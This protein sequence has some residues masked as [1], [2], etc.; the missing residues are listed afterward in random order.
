MTV[1]QQVERLDIASISSSKCVLTKLQGLG[2]LLQFQWS[3][4][5]GCPSPCTTHVSLGLLGPIVLDG[6]SYPSIWVFTKQGTCVHGQYDHCVTGKFH[7]YYARSCW[8]NGPGT[9]HVK[10][11]YGFST[12]GYP[13]KSDTAWQSLWLPPYETDEAESWNYNVLWG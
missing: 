4:Y 8:A 6:T 5:S 3:I 13:I 2:K 9:N 1:Y 11:L 7:C 10:S 12:L